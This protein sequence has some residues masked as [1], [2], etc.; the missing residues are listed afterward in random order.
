MGAIFIGQTQKC[1]IMSVL[2]RK[3]VD[4]SDF[5]DVLMSKNINFM[6]LLP[7]LRKNGDKFSE[8]E[9]KELMDTT[10]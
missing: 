9:F 7:L 10:L 2:M 1:G 6:E 3:Q 4:V 8:P 5:I